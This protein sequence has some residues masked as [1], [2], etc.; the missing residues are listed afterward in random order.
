LPR[1]NAIDFVT[2]GT[3]N[4]FDPQVIEAF[5]AVMREPE[6]QVPEQL[7]PVFPQVTA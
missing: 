3:G 2:E 4:H 6:P 7:A 1:P 5:L